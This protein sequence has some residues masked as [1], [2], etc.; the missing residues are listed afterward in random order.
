M[1]DEFEFCLRCH[2]KLKNE[3]ARKI[4]YGKVCLKKAKKQKPKA[5]LFKIKEKNNGTI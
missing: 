1:K 3:E 5:T 4:G 2:R